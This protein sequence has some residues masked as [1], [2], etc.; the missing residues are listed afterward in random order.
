M[1]EG[2][3]APRLTGVRRARPGRVALEVDGRAWRTVPD[4][5]V[6]RCG[7]AP[8]LA[9]ERPLLRALRRELR[10]AEALDAASRAL[11]RRDLSARRL[12]ERLDARGIRS[13]AAE[14][15][16]A[17]LTSAGVVDDAR[18]ASA[19][20]RSL[21]ERGWGDAAVAARLEHEGIAPEVSAA[22]LA[23]LSPEAER[24]AAVA[25]RA[26]DRPAAWRLLARRG[27]AADAIEEA[28]A[29]WTEGAAAG[30]DTDSSA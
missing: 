5:V 8:G 1:D 3:P 7:L 17:T 24:A 15:T 4:D 29:R 21:A 25:A 19:R 20:A 23:D 18:L 6:V 28:L 10:S 2:G 30:Y 11:A 9:L 14:R 12:R 27:F 26:R 22:A 16:L 13:P